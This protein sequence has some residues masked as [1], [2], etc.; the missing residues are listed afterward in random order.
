[1]DTHYKISK[2]ELCTLMMAHCITT[3]KETSTIDFEKIFA[4]LGRYFHPQ[5]IEVAYENL[6]DE[7]HDYKDSEAS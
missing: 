7:Y 5:L 2:L 3:D 4:Y 6:P 1:M